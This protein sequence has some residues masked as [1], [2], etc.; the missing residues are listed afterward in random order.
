MKTAKQMGSWRKAIV[1]NLKNSQGWKLA[2]MKDFNFVMTSSAGNF[3]A[4]L[5][6]GSLTLGGIQVVRAIRTADPGVCTT[7]VARA[8][9]HAYVARHA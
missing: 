3:A 5:T 6:G 7:V 9:P 8:R 2:A 4:N 1:H